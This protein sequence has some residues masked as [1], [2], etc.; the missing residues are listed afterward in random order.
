VID[1]R[2]AVRI[3]FR[4]IRAHKLRSALTVLGIVIGIASVITFT[5]FGASVQADVLGRIGTTNA[6]DV[7]VF[8]TSSNSSGFGQVVQPVF[9][10]HDV[11]QL[12]SVRGVRR[13]IPRGTIATS[14]I[15]LGSTTIAR[16]RVTATTPGT[17]RNRSIVAGRG[18][19][20]GANEVVLNERAVK[21]FGGNVS[22]GDSLTITFAGNRSRTMPV[23]GIVN[24]TAGQLPVS[25][26]A[27]R[28]RVYLPLHP[29]YRTIVRSP[30]LGVRQSA[31]PEVTVV[32]DPTRTRS[33]KRSIAAYLRKRSDAAQL[34]PGGTRLVA[35]TSGDFVSQ[36][37][38]VITRITRFVTGIAVIA[39]VVGAIGIANIMLVSVSERTKEI[40]IMKAVGAGNRDVMSIFLLEAASLGAIGALVG[41]P[42]GLVVAFAATRY[43]SV[44]FA[45]APV[46]LGIAVAVGVLVGVV[47]G[48]YPA[49]RAARVNPIDAL[50]YE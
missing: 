19:H 46:W 6:N 7:Y 27:G 17:F 1:A 47:A 20:A 13:V 48:L 41:I 34:K 37:G 33:A 16:R 40:G 39:L 42:V 36:I 10:Q 28:A 30:T 26:F 32:T 11:A 12:S 5:T 2:E 21:Q 24:G 45:L 8:A 14:S 25:N 49:W 23:V 4:S 44:A 18:F 35:R 31:Y 9:T 22:V 50:R 15:A 43:V 38:S 3:A 29:F